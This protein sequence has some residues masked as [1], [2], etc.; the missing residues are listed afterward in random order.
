[1]HRRRGRGVRSGV[2]DH[3]ASRVQ[4]TTDRLK[5]YLEAVDDAFG[6]DIDYAQLIKVY[7]AEK[8]GPGRYSAPAII[9]TETCAVSGEPDWRQVS[10]S[11]VER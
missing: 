11:Y 1:M 2:A 4:L 9:G 6:R 7:G 8:A 3:L 5:A 10:T